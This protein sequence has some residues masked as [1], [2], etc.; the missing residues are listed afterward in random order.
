MRASGLRVHGSTQHLT[1]DGCD[2]DRCAGHDRPQSSTGSGPRNPLH[3]SVNRAVRPPRTAPRC[4]HEQSTRRRTHPYRR[5]SG[6]RAT[7]ARATRPPW[8]ARADPTRNTRPPGDA[9]RAV[10]RG[11]A[12]RPRARIAHTLA[13][14][15]HHLARVSVRRPGTPARRTMAPEGAHLRSHHGPRSR[16]RV[17]R[18]ARCGASASPRCSR[19]GRAPCDE[20]GQDRRGRGSVEATAQRCPRHRPRP[21]RRDGDDQRPRRGTRAAAEGAVEGSDRGQDGLGA[22]GVAGRIRLSRAVPAA[23]G[24]GTGAAARVPPPRGT[25]GDRRLLVPR[26]GRRG[27]GRRPREVRGPRDARRPDHG[28]RALAGE[29]AR[30]LRCARSPRSER[31]SG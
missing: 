9:G 11:A 15:R 26:A 17:V 21:A 6:R 10:P 12:P 13:R 3:R 8:L 28:G 7:C 18:P 2:V 20:R 22:V 5:S 19:T 30:G 14:R 16:D 1:I 25:H 23:R 4:R 27:R 29:A 24:P 31:S